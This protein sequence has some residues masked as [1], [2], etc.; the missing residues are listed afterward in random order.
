MANT[1]LLSGIGRMIENEI[2]AEDKARDQALYDLRLKLEALVFSDNI[3]GLPFD[4]VLGDDGKHLDVMLNN[5]RIGR[6]V[7]EDDGYAVRDTMGGTLG[8]GAADG[9]RRAV[10]DLVKAEIYGHRKQ[11]K[12]QQRA[13]RA[14]TEIANMFQR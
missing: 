9:L 12:A 2:K 14:G 3:N 6:I 8:N 13:A 4:T 1:N 11:L 5:K 7:P 10:A